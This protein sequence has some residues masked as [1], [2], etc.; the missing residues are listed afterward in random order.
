MGSCVS[1]CK[2]DHSD[3]AMRF[4]LGVGSKATERGIS[5]RAS[6]GELSSKSKPAEFGGKEETFFDSHAWL[7][8]DGEDDFLSVSGDFTPARGST[9]NSQIST[10]GTPRQN[11]ASSD[12]TFRDKKSEPLPTDRKQKLVDLLQENQQG[13]QVG[14]EQYAINGK[15]KTN[16]KP[17]NCNVDADQIPRSRNR[18]PY[19]SGTNS[20]CSSDLTSVRDMKHHRE[21]TAKS[22]QYCL[23]TLFQSL[24]FSNKRRRRRKKKKKKSPAC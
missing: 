20:A 22:Q 1:A 24:G 7:D 15:L 17:E 8:S 16:G 3:S 4:P 13:E 18:N 9:P 23:P 14:T 21:E 6:A 11:K 12:N 19:Q 5:G 2:E 10:P